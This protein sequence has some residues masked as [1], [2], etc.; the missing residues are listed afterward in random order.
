MDHLTERIWYRSYTSEM[1]EKLVIPEKSI[2]TLFKE[3]VEKYGE[4]SAVI[5][6]G[7]TTTYSELKN[8]VDRLAS[9]WKQ[10][11]MNKGENIGLMISNH[12]NYMICFFAAQLLGMTV[13]PINP[14]VNNRELLKLMIDSEMKYLVIEQYSSLDPCE[15]LRDSQFLEQLFISGIK[16]I[17]KFRTLD[18]LIEQVEPIRKEATI[19]VR[20]DIAV[21][22]YTFCATGNT[23]RVML[24]HYNIVANVI[25]N[26]MT[27]AKRLKFGEEMIVTAVP[28]YHIYGLTTAMN[29]GV[30][31]G[32]TL[33][34]FP[35]FDVKSVLENIKKYQP[36]Y[37]PGVPYMYSAFI[38]YPNVENYGL[39]CLKNCTS[40]SIPY[41][42]EVIKRFEAITGTTIIEGYGVEEVSS[43]THRT[44]PD[45][46]RKIGSIGVPLPGT[47]CLIVDED[48]NELPPKFPG[49]LLIKGPQIMNNYWKNEEASKLKLRNGWLYT[50]DL[51]IMDEDGYFFIIGQKEEVVIMG[52]FNISVQEVEKVL[53][54]Y[55][56]IE[57]AFV[58]GIPDPR[59]GEVMKGLIV[60]KKG[61]QI[62]I[63]DVKGYC[64]L[65]LKSHKVPKF[66]EIRQGLPRNSVGKLLKKTLIDEEKN[67]IKGSEKN[68]L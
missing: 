48:S 55:P 4:R 40:G 37:F 18:H 45:G 36:T 38:D 8:R 60:P 49:E 63:E 11:G 39:E 56:E 31:I 3:T 42:S 2:Y 50:G 24:S 17:D 6:N 59:Y 43:I 57:E 16:P 5:Y 12:P 7:Q 20:E 54:E 67:R 29:L 33:L 10:I 68:E 41:P 28:L 46:L 22:Q 61:R 23:K 58:F 51:A 64:H 44:P 35:K 19:S 25:Q 9:A 14:R 34:L 1:K 32:A 62:D 30:Y 15:L 65:N 26:C 66:F 52:G 47:D 53:N 21:I 27:N 13:V